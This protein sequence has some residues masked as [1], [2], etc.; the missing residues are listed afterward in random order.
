MMGLEQH[1]ANDHRGQR[2]LNL[3]AD[4]GRNRRR[5]QA[6]AGRERRHQHWPHA[7]FSGGSH[8]LYGRHGL[9]SELIEIRNDEYTVHDRD[10]E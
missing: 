9:A 10:A 8:G 5:Q 4:P 3:T 2:P 1:P 6:D 7:F